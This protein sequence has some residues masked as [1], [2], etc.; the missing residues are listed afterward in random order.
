MDVTWCYTTAG[1]SKVKHA[2]A[3]ET[4]KNATAV[5]GFYIPWYALDYWRDDEEGLRSRQACKR[6]LRN[7]GQDLTPARE[8]AV[9]SLV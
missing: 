6:C 8:A 1:K 5:C 4:S 9:R 2:M 7:L 3:E